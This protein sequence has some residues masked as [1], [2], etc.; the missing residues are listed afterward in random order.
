MDR[1]KKTFSIIKI[2]ILL[3]ACV[4]TAFL[5]LSGA[6]NAAPTADYPIKPGPFTQV[7][8]NDVFWAPKMETNRAV[9]VPYALRKNEETGR[10]DNFRKAALFGFQGLNRFEPGCAKGRVNAED[11]T[12]RGG[13]GKSD[14]GRRPRHQRLPESKNRC[15]VR[16]A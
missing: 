10:V 14:G 1:M 13:E 2:I 16:G 11:N 4:I 15:G 5:L 9:T 8:I 3:A 12:H 6:E 7:H